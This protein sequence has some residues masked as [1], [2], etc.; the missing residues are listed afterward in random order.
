[1]VGATEVDEGED[2]ETDNLC[3]FGSHISVD[4][5]YTFSTVNRVVV[6][7]I[8]YKRASPD[9]HSL[10]LG[11][12]RRY[13]PGA[14][15]KGDAREQMVHADSF[16]SHMSKTLNRLIGQVRNLVQI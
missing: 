10:L 8:Q 13:Q 14:A 1:M 2:N 3:L 5:L 16:T 9:F 15:G 4:I 12:A 11:C 7:I 6:A